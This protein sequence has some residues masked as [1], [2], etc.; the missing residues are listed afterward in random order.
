MST[1]KIL[2][3]VAVLLMATASLTACSTPSAH[4]SGM[5]SAGKAAAQSS[6]PAPI[7][8][9]PETI[10]GSEVKVPEQRG[11]VLMIA[12]NADKWTAEIADSSIVEFVA[13]EKPVFK[14]LAVGST[15]VTLTPP[16]GEAITF[17]L[18]VT[19]GAN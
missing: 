16:Q 14:P 15:E 3:S 2:T 7:A 6:Q 12:E 19:P 5:Q 18:S 4:M 10:N 8:K 9:R 1:R 17:T 11:L 13:G